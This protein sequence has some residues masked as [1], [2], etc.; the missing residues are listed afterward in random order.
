MLRVV[1]SAVV[2][3]GAQPNVLAVLAKHLKG[4]AVPQ[5][6]RGT[7]NAITEL[8]V[9]ERELSAA[10]STQTKSYLHRQPDPALR[11]SITA[12]VREA[13]RLMPKFDKNESINFYGMDGRIPQLALGSTAVYVYEAMGLP[14]RPFADHVLFRGGHRLTNAVV[15]ETLGSLVESAPFEEIVYVYDGLCQERYADNVE[16]QEIEADLKK[17]IQPPLQWAMFLVF[18]KP[19]FGSKRTRHGRRTVATNT[20]PVEVFRRIVKMVFD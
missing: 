10:W 11:E 5:D 13:L 2:L 7:V 8:I 15:R 20:F 1:L 19:V 16:Y 18:Y 14:L 6:G 17:R 3:K 4:L 9:I 12:A